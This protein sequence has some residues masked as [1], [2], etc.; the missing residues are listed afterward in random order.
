MLTNNTHRR[1]PQA[2]AR[3]GMLLAAAFSIGSAAGAPKTAPNSTVFAL[4]ST[5]SHLGAGVPEVYTAKAFGCAG[6]NLS[7]PLHWAG[8]PSGT[9][10][11][12]LTLF[13]RDEHSTPSGWWHWV[14]YD[15]P[16]DTSELATGAG[17]LH[18]NA[19]PTG[20]LQGRSDLGENAYHGPCPAK[21]DPPHRYEFTLDALDVA[22]LPVDADSSGAMVTSVASEHRLARAVLLVHY[23]RA[24]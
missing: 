6:G 8:A 5:D 13:D 4:W 17:E 1:P 18:S 20:A 22:K 24:K 7:P 19:L 9:K 15:I 23:G 16:A 21:G 3:F 14:V 2:L 11:F 10:S 12:L